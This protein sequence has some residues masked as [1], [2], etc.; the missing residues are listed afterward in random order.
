MMIL[1]LSERLFIPSKKLRGFERGKVG[2]KDG[3]DFIG[4]NYVAALNFSSLLPQILENSQNI[5]FLFFFDIANVWG[6]DYDSS[7]R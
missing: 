6:V 2:P 7:I 4:G 5:D 1:K 3:N